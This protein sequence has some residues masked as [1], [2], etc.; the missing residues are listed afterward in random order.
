MKINK[1]ISRIF[2]TDARDYLNRYKILKE[3]ATHLGLRSKLLLELLFALECSIKALIYLESTETEKITYKKIL[4]H[5]LKK[6]SDL[7]NEKSKKEFIKIITTDL[8]VFDVDIRYQLESEIVF[9]TVNGS[10]DEKYYNTIANFSWLDN[11][12]NQITNFISYIE[13]LNPYKL[14]VINFSNINIEEV[15]QKHKII[16]SLREK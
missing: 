10:L 1:E 12:Y 13:T 6:L 5:K 11:I 2:L 8:S 15:I 9:R 7:L 14:E 4:T 3:N 16:T